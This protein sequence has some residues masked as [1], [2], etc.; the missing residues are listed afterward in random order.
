M[1]VTWYLMAIKKHY[2]SLDDSKLFLTVS[3]LTKS[4]RGRTS[5]IH[6][7]TEKLNIGKHECL[8]SDK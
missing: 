7:Q 6:S 3:L 1:S 5:T 4:I 8:M 2:T